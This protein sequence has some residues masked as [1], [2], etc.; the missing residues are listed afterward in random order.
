MDVS[1]VLKE[2]RGRRGMSEEVRSLVLGDGV[3]GGNAG[4]RSTRTL[5]LSPLAV[6]GSGTVDG[7]GAPNSGEGQGRGPGGVL[8]GDG[9]CK[10]LGSEP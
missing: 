5:I 1:E 2:E 8:T 6:S 7:R 10:E 4:G 9:H 3:T